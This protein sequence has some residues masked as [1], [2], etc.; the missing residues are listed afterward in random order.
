V[1]VCVHLNVSKIHRFVDNILWISC[2]C[3]TL[4]LPTLHFPTIGN[5]NTKQVQFCEMWTNVGRSNFYVNN[6]TY[7]NQKLLKVKILTT[8]FSYSE[9]S[10][11]Q[12]R[13]ILLVHSV[14]VQF[15]GSHIVYILYCR[16]TCNI[17]ANYMGSHRVHNHWKYQTYVPFLAWW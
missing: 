10:S 2:Q 4:S 8:C 6:T 1:C 9:L 13:N 11:G 5:N 17:N 16:S 7:I 15:M 14:I 3:R 12:K